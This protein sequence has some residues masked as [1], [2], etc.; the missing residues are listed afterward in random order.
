MT[1][2][3]RAMLVVLY[4]AT[5]Q[6]T[7]L[8]PHALGTSWSSS[9]SARSSAVVVSMMS[10]DDPLS[11]IG[12]L[13][14]G[15]IKDIGGGDVP[16]AV[17]GGKARIGGAV[18]GGLLGGPFGLLLGLGAG[19][20][21]ANRAEA[22]KEMAKLGLNKKVIEEAQTLAQTLSDAQAASEAATDARETTRLRALR[23]DEAFEGL[24][25]QAREALQRD[26]ESAA[27]GFLE[28]RQ[29]VGKQRDLAVAAHREARERCERIDRDVA[30]LQG[31]VE[32]FD[33]LILRSA[34][35]AQ[36]VGVGGDD[37]RF[38]YE[39]PTSVLGADKPSR[40]P[41]LDKFEQ[42][43]RDMEEKKRRRAA[44]EDED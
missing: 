17:S 10:S 19:D 37:E 5:P 24:Q 29:K 42:L 40:D 21:L 43:E 25:D 38:E 2:N 4:M 7:A 11:R 22:K 27:R 31:K 44:G 8:L 34:R 12:R 16:D 20:T 14:K 41:L 9:S 39:M 13:A 26:D 36:G 30:T 28:E 23:L 18:I 1:G 6:V 32:E 3:I 15:K 33:A 35:Q